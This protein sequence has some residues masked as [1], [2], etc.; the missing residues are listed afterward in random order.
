MGAVQRVKTAGV[1]GVEPGWPLPRFIILFCLDVLEANGFIKWALKVLSI[2]SV[3]NVAHRV[4]Y[5]LSV[6][7][8]QLGSRGR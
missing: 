4:C 5:L 1:G 3:I 6:K 8:F 7:L 2:L